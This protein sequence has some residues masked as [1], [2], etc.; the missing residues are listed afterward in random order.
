[1][2]K[3]EAKTF[4]SDGQR[5]LSN[6]TSLLEVLVLTAEAQE[7]GLVPRTVIDWWGLLELAKEQADAIPD[8]LNSVETFLCEQ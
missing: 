6:L 4:L 2:T 8:L 3:E 7:S 1:M 5:K